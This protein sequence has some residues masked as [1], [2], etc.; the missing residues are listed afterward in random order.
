MVWTDY[1]IIAI[2][3][4]LTIIFLLGLIGC[5]KNKEGIDF[6]VKLIIAYIIFGGICVIAFL[7]MDNYPGDAAGKVTKVNRNFFGTTAIYVRTSET[8]EEEYCIEDS[9]L[10][11]KAYGYIGKDIKLHHTARVGLYSSGACSQGPVDRI[12]LSEDN[13]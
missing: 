10:S 8:N 7:V 2:L 9:E 3:I 12:E 13:D 5:I 11:K 4:F 6:V 1:I